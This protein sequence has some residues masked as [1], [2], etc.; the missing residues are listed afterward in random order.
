M[1]TGLF[2][3]GVALATTQPAA[4]GGS[5]AGIQAAYEDPRYPGV[6]EEG[7]AGPQVLRLQVLLDRRKFSPGVID[8]VFGALTADALSAFARSQGLKPDRRL[9]KKAWKLLNADREPVLRTYTVTEQDAAGPFVDIPED[10]M[11]QARLDRLGYESPLEGLAEKFHAS[12]ALITKLNPSIPIREG[13]E[14]RVPAVENDTEPPAVAQI[15]ITGEPTAV[16]AYDSSGRLVAYY[17]ATAGSEHDPLPIGEW[18]IRGVARNPEFHYNPD[19]FWDAD[20]QHA[21]AT[22][23]PGPNSPVGVVWIDLDKEHYGIHGTPSPDRVGRIASHGC[24]RL[25]NWDA[26]RLADAVKPGVPVKI[27]ER[28]AGSRR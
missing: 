18:E 20:P 13:A 12:P 10:L 11:E 7:Y 1:R 19:L 14:I 3:L 24:I 28:R 5:R 23:P 27:R 4:S 16:A 6:L 26:S 17:P 25:T 21:K 9:T 22:L 2:L 15:E 8:G